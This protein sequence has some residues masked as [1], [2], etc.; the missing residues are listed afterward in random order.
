MIDS[1]LP[2]PGASGAS[3]KNASNAIAILSSRSA[4]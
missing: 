4:W 3:F 2:R 1:T